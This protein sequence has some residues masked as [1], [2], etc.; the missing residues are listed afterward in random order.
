[1]GKHS[2][3]QKPA[4]TPA[5]APAADKPADASTEQPSSAAAQKTQ[6]V[7]TDAPAASAG[8]QPKSDLTTEAASAATAAAGEQLQTDAR[9]SEQPETGP[10][11]TAASAPSDSKEESSD[12][13]AQTQ[14]GDEVKAADT[15][16]TTGA[17]LYEQAP[18]S[19][20]SAPSDETP[21][22]TVEAHVAVSDMPEKL[23]I[24]SAAPAPVAMAPRASVSVQSQ[25][26]QL[27][28]V[29]RMLLEN[30]IDYAAVMAPRKPVDTEQGNLNQVALYRSIVGIIE[31]TS[32]EDF[33]PAF[34]AL[35]M[36]FEESR[37]GVF[38]EIYVNRFHD[39]MPLGAEER[40]TLLNLVDLFKVLGPVKGRDQAMKQ[41]DIDRALK[42]SLSEVG[43]G[44]VSQ[45]FGF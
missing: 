4:T 1:M 29:A 7:K 42:G 15:Q 2:N 33:E 45:Y 43:R 39:T 10:T 6:D 31:R 26:D 32:D 30:I 14:S 16:A 28:P 40:K 44:R 3:H 22:A 21:A 12:A 24:A 37:D 25:L 5:Q 8:D 36:L 13:A 9:T 41:V 27:S 23:V 17:E 35:L 19:A 38:R 20:A 11:D 18:T 34:T